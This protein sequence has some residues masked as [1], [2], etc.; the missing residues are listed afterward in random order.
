MLAWE[1]RAIWLPVAPVVGEPA[2]EEVTTALMVVAADMLVAGARAWL[3]YA[4]THQ[5]DAFDREDCAKAILTAMLAEALSAVP[6]VGGLLGSLLLP[7]VLAWIARSGKWPWQS[8]MRT[9]LTSGA[10]LHRHFFQ[11]LLKARRAVGNPT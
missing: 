6:G 9:L 8:D 1:D 11:A 7:V 10:D 5:G 2:A 4:L 3:V